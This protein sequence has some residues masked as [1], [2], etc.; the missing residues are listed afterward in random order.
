[1][2]PKPDLLERQVD[3]IHFLEETRDAYQLLVL[4][5]RGMSLNDVLA[6]ETAA[7]DDQGV[8]VRD[9][10]V[11]FASVSV[12]N[13]TGSEVIIVSDPPQQSAPTLGAGVVI[14]PAGAS[15]T[16][17]IA[18]TVLTFYGPTAKRI[19]FSVFSKVQGPAFA[20]GD[21]GDA[22]AG[23]PTEPVDIAVDNTV[24]GVLLLAANPARKSAL[25][26]NTGT[27]AIRAAI[28]VAPTAARG[29]QL[30]AGAT[31]RLER[32]YIPTGE[33]RGIRE[34]AANSTAT[35]LEVT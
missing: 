5:L 22:S 21:G 3:F 11:P 30:A 14:V 35:V 1:M 24:G 29:V 28:G 2:T 12:G 15:V 7:F 25:V 33:I 31:M 26:Q 13:A 9:F 20:G 8:I 16:V 4:Q 19:T 6:T 32:P 27:A 23:V 18:G 34:G 10:T 17:P